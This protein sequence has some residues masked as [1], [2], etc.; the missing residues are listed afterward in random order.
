V[1]QGESER[2]IRDWL[3]G[4]KGVDL[5]DAEVEAAAA[6]LVGIGATAL[7]LL[8]ETYLQE[9]ETLLAVATQALRRWPEPYPIQPL[10]GL[11][12]DPDLDAMSKALILMVLEAYGLDTS[13]PEAFGLSINLEDY[14][15]H[16]PGVEGGA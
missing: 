12:K 9:D 7:P 10:L 5:P 16:A 14:P 4:M 3:E 11:L 8:L 1:V 6:R 2:E 13:S 15:I